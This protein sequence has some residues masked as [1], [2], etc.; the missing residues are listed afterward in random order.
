M[1]GMTGRADMIERQQRALLQS[2]KMASIGQLAAGVAHEIN[3][4]MGYINANLH[5]LDRYLGQIAR[6]DRLRQEA[7]EG[8]LPPR[9]R[10]AVAAG[11][12][13]LAVD[14]A[15]A[16]GV[17]LIRESLEGVERVTKIVQDLRS[18][19]RVDALGREPVSLSACLESALTI[20]HNE[21]KYVATVRREYEPVSEILCNP[22]QLN[23]V[24]L[25]LL[26]NATQAIV[27][28]GE[29]VLRCWQDAGAVYASV[30][31]NGRGMTEEV[32]RRIFEPF[33]TTKEV[34]KG[35]GLGLSISYDIVKRHRGEILV[36][37]E[38][39]KGTTFTVRLPRDPGGTA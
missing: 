25:N 35:T 13:A 8:E 22:G 14:H 12:T 19:S 2:E 15:L 32:R 18:F 5:V 20:A 34:G 24:F 10:E 39:G 23:Q 27:P 1:L 7:G 3:N 38:V 33:F 11:R 9:N 31:D 37:S 16:D 30:S 21:L 6:F 29:I 17:V 36:E 26:V 28:P 4:P